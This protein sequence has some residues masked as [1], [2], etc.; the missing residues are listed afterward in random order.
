M[1]SAARRQPQRLVL[2]GSVLIDILMYVDHLPERGGD[3]VA[4]RTMLTS[5]GG[6]NL[7]AGARRLGLSAAYAGRVGDGPMGNQ[8]IA[9]L[10]AAGIPLLL[11]RVRGEDSGFDIA[12]VEQDAERTFVTAPGIESRLRLEDLRQLFLQPGDAVYV[13]GY[14]LCYPISGASLE[15]WLPGLSEQVLLVFDP[16]P[17]VAEIPATRLEHLLTRVDIISLNAREAHILT[18]TTKLD[19]ATASLVPRIASRGLVI[20]RAGAEGC[21]IASS[22]HAPQHIPPRPTRAVDTTGAGD[23]HVAALLARLAAGDDFA[24]AAYQANVAAS[25]SVERPGPA[26]GPTLQELASTLE[27]MH[28]SSLPIFSSQPH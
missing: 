19:D 14:E 25:I 1:K 8:V 24:S 11:P 22:T 3:S 15:S 9:D 7:L 28:G 21:W 12:L 18:G 17:L 23:T 5:G 27:A 16:G 26:T 6:F 10:E 13:S 4:R 2:I 20:A